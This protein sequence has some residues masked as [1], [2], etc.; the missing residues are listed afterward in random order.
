MAAKTFPKQIFVPKGDGLTDE[1]FYT[2]LEDTR[3]GDWNDNHEFGVYELKRVGK[4]KTT[5]AVV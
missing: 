5:I 2:H 1:F 3:E 4:L